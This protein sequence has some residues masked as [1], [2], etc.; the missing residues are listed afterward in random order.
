MSTLSV[1]LTADLEAFIERMVR[2]G[3]AANKADVVRRA[4]A[5]M[6]EEEA[7]EAVLRSERE[8]R[9]GQVLHGSLRKVL[10]K[11]A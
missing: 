7:V 11:S 8:A 10:A 4:L 3:E 1:P 6:A 5:R 9:G 2:S